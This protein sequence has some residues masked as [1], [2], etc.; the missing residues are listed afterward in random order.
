MEEFASFCRIPPDGTPLKLGKATPIKH[1]RS[2]RD[3]AVK[4]M[5]AAVWVLLSAV[6]VITGYEAFETLP[7][8]QALLLTSAL[9]TL[10]AGILGVTYLFAPKAFDLTSA[11]V[12]VLRPVRSFLIPY[13]QIV[14]AR[15][16]R[17][18]TW[19]GIRLFASGGLYGF[20]GLFYFAGIGKTWTY[21]ARR[22][23]VILLKT[24]SRG[25][26]VIGPE[27]PENFLSQLLSYQE[28][29]SG[30]GEGI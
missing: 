15:P 1:Y 18:L 19:K 11:G 10:S 5:T 3:V 14:E 25:Q 24:K 22:S 20:F 6:T 21:T 17:K 28:I 30:A 2:E 26:Y 12:V 4:I 8:G 23:R 16:L 9:A 7:W 29:K 27:E 13:S